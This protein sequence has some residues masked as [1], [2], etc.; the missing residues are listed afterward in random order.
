LGDLRKS[1]GGGN[2]EQSIQVGRGRGK[3]GEKK[4]FGIGGE[5]GI[6]SL[7][8]GEKDACGC[9]KGFPCYLY[10]NQTGDGEVIEKTT[11]GQEEGKRTTN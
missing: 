8:A 7:Y 4:S 5:G 10:W 9:I 11:L 1:R 3:K 6:C 2:D